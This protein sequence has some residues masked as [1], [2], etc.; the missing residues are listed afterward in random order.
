MLSEAFPRPDGSSQLSLQKLVAIAIGSAVLSALFGL[1]NLSPGFGAAVSVAWLVLL[2]I[3]LVPE[4]YV[5]FP[6]TPKPRK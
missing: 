4:K 2:S 1:S 6:K 5:I 3:V